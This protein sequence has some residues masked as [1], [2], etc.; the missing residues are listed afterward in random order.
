LTLATIGILY[1][2]IVA[3][4]TRDLKRLVAYSSVAQVG[5]IVLG[6][7]ALT[8]QALT[9]AVL[10]MLNH[11]IITAAF[12]LLIGWLVARRG[13]SKIAE[14]TGLQGPAPVM[15]AIFTIVMLASI[16]LPGLSGFVSEY[17]V[18]LGTFLVHRWWALVATFGV[19]AA[20]MYLLWAYQRVFHG[21]AEGE[22]AAIRDLTVAERLVIAP[23]IALIIFLG[24]FPSPVLN[25]IEPSVNRIVD[26]VSLSNC[27]PGLVCT[28]APIDVR[29]RTSPASSSTA[30][31]IPGA[32]R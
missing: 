25:R 10:L 32:N 23:L 6:T 1:G 30:T 24:V 3:C 9:G 2:A 29:S 21:K 7:F 26:Q 17:L 5:F 12:F 4:A 11:G 27:T 31:T 16:G 15:A 22:N 20:A 13:T 8:P 28:H 18:L 19:V 14:L